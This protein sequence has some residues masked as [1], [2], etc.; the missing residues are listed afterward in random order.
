MVSQ[1]TVDEGKAQTNEL[2]SKIVEALKVKINN[3]MAI[4]EITTALEKVGLN[5]YTIIAQIFLA[6]Y[7]E[8]KKRGRRDI[9]RQIAR[10]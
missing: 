4:K 2:E 3:L 7:S 9:K 1:T 8:G 5:E 6:V 10:M